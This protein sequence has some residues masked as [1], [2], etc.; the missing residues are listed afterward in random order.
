MIC[1]CSRADGAPQGRA[2]LAADAAPGRAVAVG[3]PAHGRK[4]IRPEACA[5]GVAIEQK[6]TGAPKR[7]CDACLAAARRRIRNAGD[8][9]RR[10]ERRQ[11]SNQGSAEA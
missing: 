8:R 10:A 2:V 9:R 3:S 7:F 5:C 1:D 11:R 4:K 6:A